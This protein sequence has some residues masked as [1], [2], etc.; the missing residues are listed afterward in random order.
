MHGGH[1]YGHFGTCNTVDNTWDHPITTPLPSIPTLTEWV[2]IVL[3]LSVAGF[4]VWH[5]KRRRKAALTV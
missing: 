1:I 5:L 4:F 3:A 2:L